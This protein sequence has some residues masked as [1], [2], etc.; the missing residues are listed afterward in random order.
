MRADVTMEVSS[1][2]FR[3][4]AYM[5][6]VLAALGVMV[7][8]SVPASA[9]TLTWNGNVSTAWS[10]AGNWSPA[11]VPANGDSLVF[12]AFASQFECT[13]F[14]VTVAS[15]TFDAAYSLSSGDTVA[16]SG[17]ISITSGGQ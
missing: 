3:A 4:G 7:M 10:D 5:R 15:M 9:A 11:A 6:L 2:S 1:V 17:G 14:A 12:P 8:V 13:P 16:I